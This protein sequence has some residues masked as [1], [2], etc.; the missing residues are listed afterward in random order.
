ME[1]EKYIKLIVQM[2]QTLTESDN[3]FIKQIYILIK[4]HTERKRRH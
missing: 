3:L 1:N 2:L 4:K